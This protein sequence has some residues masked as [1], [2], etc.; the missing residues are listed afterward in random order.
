MTETATER[1]ALYR[2]FNESGG[3]LYVGITNDPEVRWAYHARQKAW[4]S[5]VRKR[6][7]EWKATR[8]EAEAAEAEAIG[9]ENPQWNAIRPDAD[10]RMLHGRKGGRPATGQTKAVTFRADPKLRAAFD[11]TIEE[12]RSRSDVL[13]ELMHE[14]VNRKRRERPASSEETTT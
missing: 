1:T 12:G 14:R 2:L 5:D 6:T 13:I 9:R 4:W 8:A 7:I 3:L 10:G 11:A